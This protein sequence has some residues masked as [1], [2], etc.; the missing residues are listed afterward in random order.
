MPLAL[1]PAHDTEMDIPWPTLKRIGKVGGCVLLLV[2]LVTTTIDIVKRKPWRP[3]AEKVSA[4]TATVKSTRPE[5]LPAVKS[6][7]DAAG[8]KTPS[9]APSHGGE[10]VPAAAAV[11]DAAAPA[12]VAADDIFPAANPLV[13]TP[14]AFNK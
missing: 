1:L 10:S 7:L 3:V 4:L 11:A 12:E 6:W 5:D 2:I 9:S 14:H 8:K 13:P